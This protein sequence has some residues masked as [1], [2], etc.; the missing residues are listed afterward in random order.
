MDPVGLSDNNLDTLRPERRS[1]LQALCTALLVAGQ[2]CRRAVQPTPEFSLVL[3]DHTSRNQELKQFTKESGVRVELLPAPEGTVETLDAW[4]N[5]LEG[6]AKIP[7][8]YAIDVIWPGILAENLIDLKSCVPA[9]EIAAHFPE[10]IANNAVNGKLVA[11]PCLI[12]LGLL[13]Y[14][15]DLLARYRY[16]TPPETWEELESMAAEIQ[17]GERARGQ[18]DFWG[19]VWE[20]ASSETLTCNALEWEVS[21]GGG[22]IFDNET[23]TVNNPQTAR[24]WERA[25]RWVGTIS[26]PGVL[27]YKAWDAYNIWQAGDAAF[28]RNWGTLHF[29]EVVQ[30]SLTSDQFT[31]TSLPRGLAGVA[32]TLGGRSYAISRHSIHPREASMLVRF[33]CRPDTQFDRSRTIGAS[34]TIPELYNDLKMLAP[35]PYFSMFLKSYRHDKVLRPSTGMGKKY[36]DVSRAYFNAAHE[37]LSRKKP[38]GNA[39]ADLQTELMRITGLKAP[40]PRAIGGP[41]GKAAT[42]SNEPPRRDS[43]GRPV[44]SGTKL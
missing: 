2:A 37:V 27:A 31:I 5:L 35:N 24:A 6:G 12:D 15:T 28:M 17:A 22:P 10:L 34:P 1:F 3:I 20:G 44:F 29:G 43:A 19:F 30:G 18:K 41:P 9:P 38:V 21:E 7:D 40:V 25:A 26:P 11:L 16:R 4:R 14:R 33:L 42:S 32:S 39:L 8:V 23:V 13:F 36:P